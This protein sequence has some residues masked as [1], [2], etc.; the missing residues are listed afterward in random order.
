MKKK[1]TKLAASIGIAFTQSSNADPAIENGYSE[2]NTDVQL[3]KLPLNMETPIFLAAHSSH[4]S[5]G[6]HGSHGSHRSSSSTG[7][8]KSVTSNP[9]GTAKPRPV[10]SYP[11]KQKCPD[12]LLSLRKNVVRQVQYHLVLSGDLDIKDAIG[13][14]GVIDFNTRR[15]I[16]SF[17]RQKGI[18]RVSGTTLDNSTLNVMGISCN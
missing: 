6:S 1:F 14:L 16:L 15:A 8:S 7:V 18:S 9:L 12:H 17:Q 4:K 5:H 2:V 11:P 3:Y 13:S 10:T